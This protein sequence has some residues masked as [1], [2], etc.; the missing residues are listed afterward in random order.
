[1]AG[2]PGAV[3]TSLFF[4]ALTV[5]TL[6]VELGDERLREQVGGE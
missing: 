6:F 2:S 1:L 4:N 3:I 5:C